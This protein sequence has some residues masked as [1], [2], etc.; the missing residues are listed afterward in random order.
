VGPIAAA[1]T[2]WA[3]LGE[4]P[5]SYHYLGAVLILGGMYLVNRRKSADKHAKP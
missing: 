1:L 4:V 5:K 2:G 3:L